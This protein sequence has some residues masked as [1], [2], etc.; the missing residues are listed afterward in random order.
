MVEH[1]ERAALAADDSSRFAALLGA[2]MEQVL[3]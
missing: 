2:G 3:A 1:G